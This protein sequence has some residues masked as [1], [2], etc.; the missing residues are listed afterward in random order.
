MVELPAPSSRPRPRLRHH[1]FAAKA[2]GVGVP[3]KARYGA[4]VRRIFTALRTRNFRRFFIG[5]VVS[6]TRALNITHCVHSS[7]AAFTLVDATFS[8]GNAVHVGVK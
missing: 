5:Q 8:P 1:Y 3:V 4:T 6:N 2:P 7:D